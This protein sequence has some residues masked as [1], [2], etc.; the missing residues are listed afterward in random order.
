MSDAI[1]VF[2][3]V[4]GQFSRIPVIGLLGLVMLATGLMLKKIQ[5]FPNKYIPIVIMTMGTIGGAY[6]GNPGKI[7]PD[8]PYPRVILAF[9]GFLIGFVV[10][11]AHKWLLKRFEKFLPEGF[12]QNGFHTDIIKKSDVPPIPDK[13]K[14]PEA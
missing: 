1:S 8:Q 6:L 12:F 14:D 3:D 5:M 10:W 4:I 11:G 9:Y 7:D 13:P 2:T